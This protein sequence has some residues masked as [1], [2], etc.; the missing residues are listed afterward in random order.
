VEK[1]PHKAEGDSLYRF[2]VTGILQ[3]RRYLCPIHT[4]PEI[5]HTPVSTERPQSVGNNRRE[6]VI[7]YGSMFSHIE[8]FGINPF[9]NDHEEFKDMKQ[10]YI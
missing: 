2:V 4:I 6:N 9:I 7:P 8:K 3:H 10:A 1:C 5:S